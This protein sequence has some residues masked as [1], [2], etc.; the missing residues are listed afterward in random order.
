MCCRGVG[1][2]MEKCGEVLNVT[3]L[4]IAGIEL[5][6][7]NPYLEKQI[8]LTDSDTSVQDTIDVH[9]VCEETRLQVSKQAK[10]I[11]EN[12]IDGIENKVNNAIDELAE[13]LP[14][15]II[16][17]FYHEI[18]DVFENEIRDTLTSYISSHVSQDCEE[19]VRILNLRDSTR[20]KETQ[21][22]MQKTLNDAQTL[23]RQ[24]ARKKQ[25]SIFKKMVDCLESYFCD[26]KNLAEETKRKL[27]ELKKHKDDVSYLCEQATGTAVDIAYMECI[28][29][30]TYNR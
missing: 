28:R 24:K 14:E 13:L 19:F 22:Y 21:E 7:N 15:S 17:E 23:L 20:E 8:D 16:D 29:M 3:G 27:E 26:E 2:V 30:L 10:I 1:V 9:K 25:I 6:C 5:Q 12:I 11:E 18:G 4:E